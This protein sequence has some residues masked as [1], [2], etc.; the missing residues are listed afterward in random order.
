MKKLVLVFLAVFVSACTKA[1]T[2]NDFFGTW[3][4]ESENGSKME[5]VVTSTI[6]TTTYTPH[7]LTLI[8]PVERYTYEIFS[9]EKITNNDV[10][11]KG[12]YP[13]GFLIGI[14]NG[15]GYTT[16][17]LF[18]NRNNNSL[19]SIYEH[20]GVKYRDIYFKQGVNASTALPK[21]QELFD[22][23][24]E[25]TD[26]FPT[27][28]KQ[29]IERYIAHHFLPY[30][31]ETYVRTYDNV[32]AVVYG[33]YPNSNNDNIIS[34]ILEFSSEEAYTETLQNLTSYLSKK[35]EEN[36]NDGKTSQYSGKA[37]IFIMDASK[38]YGGFT[39]AIS[40]G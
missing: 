11:S 12:D 39:I 14:K 2:Q 9:W 16:L 30:K 23:I 25:L 24:S 37:I 7:I 4:Y 29:A 27:N 31:D 17:S 22:F 6:F 38:I 32:K 8:S 1:Q 33:E 10:Y 19:I 18:I 5:Y 3:L 20:N 40:I 15:L 28:E 34:F 21:Q 13:A 36:F 26:N 35:Y